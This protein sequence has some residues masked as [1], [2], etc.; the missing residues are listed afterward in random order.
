MIETYY[1]IRIGNPCRHYPYLWVGEDG[2]TPVLFATKEKAT[3][4]LSGFD[5]ENC[6]K[7]VKVRICFGR[8]G[9][10]GKP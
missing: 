3:E 4:E 7:V 10:G 9:Q 5:R 6:A 2:S 8:Q 1:A